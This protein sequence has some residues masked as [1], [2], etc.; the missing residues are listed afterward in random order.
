VSEHAHS[1]WLVIALGLLAGAIR[2]IPA[3][4]RPS[5]RLPAYLVSS[6]LVAVLVAV[7]QRAAGYEPS[8]AEV[9]ALAF[10]LFAAINFGVILLF[11][12]I[13]PRLGL[14]VPHILV[15][16][17]AGVAVVIALIAVGKRA[18]FSVAGLITTSAVLTAV[19]GFSMQDTLGNIMGGL[20]LQLDN[21]IRIGDWVSLGAG[22][23]TGRV[24]EIRWRYTAIE[25]RNWETLII[26]NST[27]MKNAMT[28]LGKRSEAAELWRRVVEFHVDFRTSPTDV[29]AS[30]QAALR[31]DPPPRMATEP[32]PFVIFHGL[33]ESYATYAVIYWLADLDAD[34]RGDSEVRV[35]VWYALERAGLGFSI[36]AQAIFVTEE[37]HERDVRRETRE[38][39]RRLAA[40][41][42]VDLFR[43]VPVETRRRLAAQMTELPFARGET[44]T[45]EGASG[46]DGLYLIVRGH[47]SVRVGGLAGREV[48]ALDGG[49]FFGEMSLMTGE[50]RAATVVATSDLRCYRVDKRAFEHVLREHPAIADEVVEVLAE[51]RAALAAARDELADVRRHRLETERE[52]LLGRL[53]GFFGLFEDTGD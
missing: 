46:D 29:I 12:A 33:G 24:T 5:L 11:R 14:Q 18:G 35:R 21:S 42:R 43:L 8:I 26:P 2:L 28:V 44:V 48:A 37:S 45:R 17:L 22:Q 20:A 34:F 10:E 38:L 7:V 49:D 16:L 41:D 15:D 50:R 23:P 40:L 9:V 31:A 53:R 36:P 39:D 19:I 27:L 25:T 52:N 47:A 6:H 13:L 1:L 32:A 30:V 4:Q 3:G 51:R